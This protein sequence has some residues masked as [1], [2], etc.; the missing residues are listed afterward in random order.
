MTWL[1]LIAPIELLKW[2]FDC[3]KGL[4]RLRLQCVTQ[5]LGLK[6]ENDNGIAAKFSQQITLC[7]TRTIVTNRTWHAAFTHRCGLNSDKTGKRTT[8]AVHAVF[9]AHSCAPTGFSVHVS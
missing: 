2:I 8:V 3:H 7:L 1:S 4:L 9:A 6:P 5:R